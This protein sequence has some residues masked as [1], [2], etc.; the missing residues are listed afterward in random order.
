[1]DFNLFS[2]GVG[3]SVSVALLI[4]FILGLVHGITPDE[5]TW[6]IV[7]SYSIG[8]YS[9]KGGFKTGMV[10]S[11]G[12]TIQR[13]FVTE[14][15]FFALAGFMEYESMT[16]IVYT[17]IGIVMLIT[18]IYV[19]NKGKYVHTH[20][21]EKIVHLFCYGGSKKCQYREDS[22][23]GFK[24][25]HEETTPKQVSS[26][27]AFVHGL[28]AGFGF[29]PFALLLI[30]VLAPAMG[31]PYLAF[32]PGLL[33]GIGTMIMQIILGSAIGYWLESRKYSTEEIQ[34]IGKK[35]AG[36]VILLGG[37]VFIAGGILAL[38]YPSITNVGV[39]TGIN[40]PNLDSINLGFLMVMLILAITLPSYFS[41]VRELNSIKKKK[42]I[43][44]N[45]S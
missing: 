41:T 4:S 32:L 35:T 25:E 6:P 7:F 40:I 18:G 30:T 43:G 24:S 11:T 27:M 9:S 17:I 38:V 28:I 33:F 5:H 13:A 16:G 20:F 10:F 44:A 15:A 2:P 22:K 3:I 1:M 23:D 21:I 29:G 42:N 19:L 45:A 34:Y 12:F 31:S 14:I 36:K 39:P 8:S 37:I 26:K